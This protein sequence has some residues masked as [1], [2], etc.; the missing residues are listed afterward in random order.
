MATAKI[1]K[2]N[3]Y[4]DVQIARI[5]GDKIKGVSE[6]Y[7][8]NRRYVNQVTNEFETKQTYEMAHNARAQ[9]WEFKYKRIQDMLNSKKMT[10]A[11]ENLQR[12]LIRS[13]WRDNFDVQEIVEYTGKTAQSV[14][15]ILFG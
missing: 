4:L 7:G 3:I 9:N 11:D 10:K 12:V 13:M 1:S 14:Q 5:T 8:C 2:E 6:K 15:I